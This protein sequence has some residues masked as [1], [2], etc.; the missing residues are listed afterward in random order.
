MGDIPARIPADPKLIGP[1]RQI[2]KAEFS[3]G[4]RNT[5]PEPI[6][7]PSLVPRLVAQKIFGFVKHL[8]Q[9]IFHGLI[10]E[11]TYDSFELAKMFFRHLGHCFVSAPASFV[12]F[13]RLAAFAIALYY[14]GNQRA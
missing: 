9:S 7:R 13:G 10:A 3:I 1:T 14:W 11:Y 8:G 12:V 5:F 6:L 2:L 4:R